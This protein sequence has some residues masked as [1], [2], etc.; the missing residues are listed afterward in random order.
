MAASAYPSVNAVQV[1]FLICCLNLYLWLVDLVHQFYAGS[2]NMTR[3]DAGSTESANT[4]LQIHALVMSLNLTAIEI[5]TINSLDSW[6]G[7]VLVMVSG[8]VKTKD[9]VNRRIF[10]QTF[11]LAPQEKG[12]YVL[13]DIFLFVDDGAV[14]QQD[15]PP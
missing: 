14:Y 13:N 15:L 6:N 12:Y 3:I 10:V 1:R 5:K 9:F 8:S 11:F 2:S 4:M 7:G